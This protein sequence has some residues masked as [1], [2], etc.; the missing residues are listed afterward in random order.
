M[1]G[2]PKITSKSLGNKQF[3]RQHDAQYS[4]NNRLN[5]GVRQR[6]NKKTSCVFSGEQFIP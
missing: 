2:I 6:T 1:D 5:P 4:Y 3:I